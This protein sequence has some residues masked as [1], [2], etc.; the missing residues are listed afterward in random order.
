MG[1]CVVRSW[2][3][4]VVMKRRLIPL[5]HG[6]KDRAN[7]E[8]G[9]GRWIASLLAFNLHEEGNPV[10]HATLANL[11]ERTPILWV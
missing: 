9:N 11:T 10:Q 4:N 2:F 6:R 8:S 7:H 3:A 5:E 1:T